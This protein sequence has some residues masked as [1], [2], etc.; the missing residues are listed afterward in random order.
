MTYG[1]PDSIIVTSVRRA[2]R[3]TNKTAYRSSYKNPD[4]WE[5][6]VLGLTT[7]WGWIVKLEAW[8]TRK[9]K[10]RKERKREARLAK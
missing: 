5:T 7:L 2:S 4:K 9:L 10:E 3:Y 1:L 6:T 8:Q